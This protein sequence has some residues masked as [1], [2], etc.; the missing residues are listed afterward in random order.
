M[1]I[2]TQPREPNLESSKGNVKTSSI[3]KL[4]G[5]DIDLCTRWIEYGM[6]PEMNWSNM[7]MDHVK[8]IL[9]FDVSKVEK[10]KAFNWKNTQPL[11][12]IESSQR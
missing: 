5:I 3:K 6:S 4:L 11:L 1:Q 9:S 7:H 2:D 12:K 10:L 8:P